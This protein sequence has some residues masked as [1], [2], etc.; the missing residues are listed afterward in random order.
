MR[1][2]FVGISHLRIHIKYLLIEI[3][4]FLVYFMLKKYIDVSMS[5]LQRIGFLG[6]TSINI[7]LFSVVVACTQS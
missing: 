7:L 3:R 1:L 4:V 2:E 5:T 6:V